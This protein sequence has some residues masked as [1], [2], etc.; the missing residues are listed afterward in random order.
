[1]FS[2]KI[3]STALSRG[4]GLYSLAASQQPQP[5]ACYHRVIREAFIHSG[6]MKDME[7]V[8]T[9]RSPAMDDLSLSLDHAQES[10][11]SLAMKGSSSTT[12]KGSLL[13]RE[14]A[15]LSNMEKLAKVDPVL[16]KIIKDY[17]EEIAIVMNDDSHHAVS[18]M[19]SELVHRLHECNLKVHRYLSKAVS[20]HLLQEMR[21]LSLVNSELAHECAEMNRLLEKH[22]FSV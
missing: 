9:M 21:F 3:F 11:T 7:R 2:K 19:E 1:M 18:M 4:R 14:Q 10:S 12:S 22:M 15:L 16:K 5:L 17:S 13:K 8:S 6:N 20:S